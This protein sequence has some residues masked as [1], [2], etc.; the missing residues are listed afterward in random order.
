MMGFAIGA[1]LLV[2]GALLLL[3]LP[4]RHR[5]A[6]ADISRTASWWPCSRRT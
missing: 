4:L 3:L 1:A 5:P 6:S 2:G